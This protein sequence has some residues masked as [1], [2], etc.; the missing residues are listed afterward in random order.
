ML[1]K[2]RATYCGSSRHLTMGLQTLKQE[3]GQC[4]GLN[5]QS[6]EV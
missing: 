5:L 1:T 6:V 2:V 3:A 4:V